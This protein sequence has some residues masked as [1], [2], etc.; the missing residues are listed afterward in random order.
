MIF[1]RRA[2]LFVFA[3]SLGSKGLSDGRSDFWQTALQKFTNT[4]RNTM[5]GSMILSSTTRQDKVERRVYDECPFEYLLY[6]EED[7]GECGAKKTNSSE[8]DEE[9]CQEG[10]CASSYGNDKWL[11]D[12]GCNIRCCQRM[13]SNH[14]DSE[15]LY[16]FIYND[17]TPPLTLAGGVCPTDGSIQ[18]KSQRICADPCA[19][20][21]SD[22]IGVNKV[23]SCLLQKVE[24]TGTRL[25][26]NESGRCA[27]NDPIVSSKQAIIIGS[28]VAVVIVAVVGV[29]VYVLIRRKRKKDMEPDEI[30]RKDDEKN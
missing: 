9:K 2:V 26:S 27:E 8:I 15:G 19:L 17:Y 10:C 25:S 18:Q 11:S 7:C 23:Q 6:F 22:G 29:A 3:I 24:V 1:V 12:I 13:I 4:H 20:L 21:I 16:T 28:V 14:P 5:F 30:V